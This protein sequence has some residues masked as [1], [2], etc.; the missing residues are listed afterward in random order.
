[1]IFIHSE[2][3][4]L[5]VIGK[6]LICSKAGKHGKLVKRL[7]EHPIQDVALTHCLKIK[8]NCLIFTLLKMT[9]ITIVDSKVDFCAKIWKKIFFCV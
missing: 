2:V 1:M 6:L 5:L 3:V 4:K 8:Q 7:R 9:K